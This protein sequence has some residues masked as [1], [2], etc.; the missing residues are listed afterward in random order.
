AIDHL[1]RD[2]IMA[3]DEEAEPFLRAQ[4]EAAGPVG[5]H[6]Q[7][8]ILVRMHLSSLLRDKQSWLEQTD[9]LGPVIREIEQWKVPRVRLIPL[10]RHMAMGLRMQGR[11]E[12]ADYARRADKIE[13]TCGYAAAS[14]AAQEERLMAKRKRRHAVQAEP[15]GK[16]TAL[17]RAQV[18]VLGTGL[19][20][21]L[22]IGGIVFAHGV[23]PAAATPATPLASAP[24]PG[25]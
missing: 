19:V 5:P 20:A 1:A 22:T 8:S 18:A 10:L 23:A 6:N 2:L 17:H 11:P 15:P 13:S 25:L 12:Y 14:T 4:M 3:H 7:I 21:A 24:A 16:P 9:L